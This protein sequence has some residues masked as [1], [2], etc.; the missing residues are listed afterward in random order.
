MYIKNN[1]NIVFIY[2]AIIFFILVVGNIKQNN[3]GGNTVEY[4][5]ND[6]SANVNILTPLDG[7]KI[8]IE[9]EI[10]NIN[11]QPL[12]DSGIAYDN[13]LR[14][15]QSNLSEINKNFGNF[16]YIPF[17]NI[18]NIY[19]KAVFEDIPNYINKLLNDINGKVSQNTV[20]IEE[21]QRQIEEL[22]K[23]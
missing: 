13:L 14:G 18:I 23:R 9:S 20:K 16:N 3:N 17:M 1:S 11:I 22:K 4:F 10:K 19:G 21:L 12:L 6:N 5:A 2:I 7:S 15:M 8:A